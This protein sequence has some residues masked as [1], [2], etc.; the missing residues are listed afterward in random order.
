MKVKLKKVRL[1]FPDLWTA[2]EF[3]IGDGKPRFNA[4][5]LIEPGSD[6]D[7][8][9]RDAIREAAKETFGAKWEAILKS[10]EGNS[11]KFAYLDGNLKDYD[12]YEGMMY[13]ACHTK[14]KPYICDRDPNVVLAADSGKPY[15]GCY[16]NATV[17]IYAQKG[18]NQGVRASF[19]GVQ[20][21]A[22]GDA[23]SAGR[24]AT[25]DDF[26]TVEDGAGGDML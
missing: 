18:E 3:K 2:T 11:N 22:D 20:F 24:P 5:F 1:S 17:D 15:A 7:K 13:L 21:A 12:G 9:I 25:A 19:S 4:T 6:N 10:L 26:D 8:A 16:V 23:F 14:T